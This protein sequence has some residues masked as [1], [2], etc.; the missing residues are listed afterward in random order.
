[1]PFERVAVTGVGVVSALGHGAAST[2]DRLV[3]GERGIR[4]LRLF[5]PLDARCRF[6]AEVSDLDVAAVAPRAEA[7][8]WSRADAMA[9]L[10]SR[11]ALGTA[12][13][14]AGGLGVSLGGT[15]GGMLETENDLLGGPL[16]RIDPGRARRLLSDPLDIT[17]VRVASAVGATRVATLCAACSSGALS[18]VR[19]IEWLENGSVER[20]LAGGVDGLCRLTFFG[21]DSLGALSAEPCR[22]F[23]RRRSG[24]SL[25][26]GA[27]F[28]LLERESAARERGAEILAF[29]SGAASGAEAHHITHPEPSGERAAE[30]VRRA[31][32]GARLTPGDLDYVNAHGTGTLQNDAME[33]K[34][35][36][37]ALGAETGRIF[38]SSSKGQLG[39]T[40]GAAGALEAA[41]TVLALR[42][43]LAPPTGGL[44]E[45]EVPGFRHVFTRGVEAP[46]RAALSGSFGFGGT[47][48]VLVFERA[49]AR[50]R[51]VAPARGRSAVVTG[52]SAIAAFGSGT[53]GGVLGQAASAGLAAAG[54]LASDPLAALDPE[55][56][57]RFDRHAALVALGAERALA[58]A[59]VKPDGVGLSV[60][61]AFGSV[62]RSVRFLLRAVE[63]GVRRA[64]PAEFPHLVASAASGNGS[65]YLGLTG[66]AVGCSDGEA[67]SE[68]ALAT[69]LGFLA[70]GQ[71]E[72]FVAGGAE[73][74]DPIVAELRAAPGGAPR[75]EGAGFLVVENAE[76][77][78][79]RGARVLAELVGTWLVPAGEGVDAAAP[80]PQYGERSCAIW[81]RA[82]NEA[83]DPRAGSLWR[84]H[85]PARLERA[86]G[87]HEANGAL[88]LVLAVELIVAGAMDEV[89]AC[90]RGR[91]GLWLSLFRRAELA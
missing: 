89:L 61:T 59:G 69:A 72:A 81:T 30:L 50:R 11:E 88:G 7:A 29:L 45:P 51:G 44:E 10:A 52:T 2:F 84:A 76:T 31:L 90:R 78:R 87:D 73:G 12:L 22:P 42:R 32:A 4:E 24:L 36:A 68:A 83:A 56:S 49:D 23:D 63:R 16:D 58:D 46:L 67:S 37:L 70:A 82:P 85:E 13:G 64:N 39:H 57:R 21:F 55:R 71:A 79:L 28:L 77:A 20:V 8:R 18:L 62:E 60:G 35:L 27:A 5:D 1:M 41:L 34:A 19:A 40:L 17:S 53:S 47:G 38:V 33:T 86:A 80:A 66:P 25:G 65:I 9:V 54:P 43:G 6:A 75:S 14:R 15:T 26:E 3:A 91:A 48:C 74:F